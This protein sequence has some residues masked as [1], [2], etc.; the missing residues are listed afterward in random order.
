[1]SRKKLKLEVGVFEIIVSGT[2]YSSPKAAEKKAMTD[3]TSP[4]DSNLKSETLNIE[5]STA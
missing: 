1:M 4:T 2:G 5:D 3:S